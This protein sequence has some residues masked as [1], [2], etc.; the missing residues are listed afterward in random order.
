MSQSAGRSYIARIV[1]STLFGLLGALAWPCGAW[2]QT[3]YLF[4]LPGA[5]VPPSRMWSTVGLGAA[6]TRNNS[7]GNFFGPGTGGGAKPTDNSWNPS[8]MFSAAVFLPI[9]ENWFAGIVTNVILPPPGTTVYGATPTAIPVSSHI[10][11]SGPAVDVMG[12]IGVSVHRELLGFEK[13]F[14]GEVGVEYARY[15]GELLGGSFDDFIASTNITSAIAGFGMGV[16]LC[17]A[18]FGVN[19]PPANAICPDLVIEATHTF[20]NT[21]WNLGMTP[22][23]SGAASQG[24]ITRVTA[25]VIF[26]LNSDFWAQALNFGTEFHY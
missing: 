4:Q 2:A 19:G 12:R 9:T 5:H 25:Q 6:F 17:Q 22:L 13:T 1:Y 23:S 7:E 14:F 15:K 10:E 26:P 21:N 24:G 18:L 3:P 20:T 8:L 16:P 11:Q